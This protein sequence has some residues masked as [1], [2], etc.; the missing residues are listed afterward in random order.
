MGTSVK[1]APGKTAVGLVKGGL[2]RVS[3][4]SLEVARIAKRQIGVL[5]EVQNQAKLGQ[6]QAE[7]GQS[8]DGGGPGEGLSQKDRLKSQR[9][10]EA[11]ETEIKDIRKQKQ[12]KTLEEEEPLKQKRLQEE[13]ALQERPLP[14]VPT[15]P[16]RGIL[17][18]VA[19]WLSKKQRSSETRGA[20]RID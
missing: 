10:I 13:Q 16:K 19:G 17:G 11:L 2:K 6:N 7:L 3:S 8:K 9:L 12:K 4:E 5:P 15:K 20:R 1:G 14:G 18:G